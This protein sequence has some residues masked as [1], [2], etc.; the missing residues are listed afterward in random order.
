[1]PSAVGTSIAKATSMLII[2]V[3]CLVDKF[4]FVFSYGTLGFKTSI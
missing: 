2:I 3:F 1:M 4:M